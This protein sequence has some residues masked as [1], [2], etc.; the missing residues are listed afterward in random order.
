MRAGTS[1]VLLFGLVWAALPATAQVTVG[2]TPD[3]DVVVTEHDDPLA[4]GL[5][6]GQN[7]R[8]VAGSY[9]SGNNHVSLSESGLLIQGGFSSCADARAGTLPAPGGRTELR[10]QSAKPILN[11]EE[12]Y[13]T[14]PGQVEL[15][16]LD[17]VGRFFA[18]E[19]PTLWTGGLVLRGWASGGALTFKVAVADSDFRH[20]DTL[21]DG[22][23][24]SATHVELTMSRSRVERN[25][26]RRGGGLFCEASGIVLDPYTHF[27]GNAAHDPLYPEQANGGAMA[28]LECDV[29]IRSR[30]IGP[31]ASDGSGISENRAEG[32]GAAIHAA[33]STLRI[34]GGDDCGSHADC[35]LSLV[36]FFGNQAQGD[37]GALYLRDDTTLI[38]NGV[39]MSNNTAADGG[40]IA[41][42]NES[43]VV[44]GDLDVAGRR[45]C[46]NPG[47]CQVLSGN[48]AYGDEAGAGLGGAIN[49]I[50]SQV[51]LNN[52]LLRDNLAGF[53]NAVYVHDHSQLRMVQA[54]VSQTR[55]EGKLLGQLSLVLGGNSESEIRHSTFDS[56]IADTTVLAVTEQAQL[57]LEAT[58][59]RSRS[60]A[61]SVRAASTAHVMARC[62]AFGGAVVGVDNGGAGLP[63]GEG[64]FDTQMPWLPRSSA[65]I[66]RCTPG[67]TEVPPYDLLGKPR[68]LAH[69]P[70][71]MAYPL[72]VGA[73]ELQAAIF[74]D[75]FE[76]SVMVR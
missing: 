10:Q 27:I 31:M 40:A 68:V 65:M 46:M 20:F 55:T 75:G 64:D 54:V 9:P 1:A 45:G 56:A 18:Y 22:G 63:I 41:V 30:G 38:A 24:I 70:G 21:A 36:R 26:G 32:R 25:R 69:Y 76:A 72:D 5:E 73:L 12:W 14:P 57:L 43:T 48:H 62:N 35:P 28:L 33:G 71:T 3:C 23:A 53:G 74:S 47:F 19:L 2:P 44:I 4:L 52:T 13:E 6:L 29:T 7:L 17:F 59:I 61:D 58:A 16:N 11:L 50:R 66:D 60:G 15:R 42:R 37:G 67:L 8:L 39:E 49:A 34:A 51:H